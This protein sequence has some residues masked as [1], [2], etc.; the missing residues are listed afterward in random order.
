M[1]STDQGP[2][3]VNTFVF[4]NFYLHVVAADSMGL[5]SSKAT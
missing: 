3:Y 5:S 2:G 4:F 1:K